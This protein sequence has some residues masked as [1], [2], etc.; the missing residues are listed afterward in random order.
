MAY[1][2]GSRAW[3]RCGKGGH[4]IDHRR[5]IEDDAFPQLLVDP[6]WY[7]PQ[8]PQEIPVDAEDPQAIYRPAVE[9]GMGELPI[10]PE[11]VARVVFSMP[12]TLAYD[13]E[14]APFTVT[15]ESPTYAASFFGAEVTFTVLRDVSDGVSTVDYTLLDG[16][17]VASLDYVGA[18]GT[19]TFNDGESSKDVTVTLIPAN[20]NAEVAATA[21][22]FAHWPLGETSGTTAADVVNGLDMVTDTGTVLRNQARNNLSGAASSYFNDTAGFGRVYPPEFLG[23]TDICIEGW[24]TLLDNTGNAATFMA[25]GGPS[26]DASSSTNWQFWIGTVPSG[27]DAVPWM[28]WEHGVGVNNTFTWTATTFPLNTPVYWKY[29][30][31]GGATKKVYFSANDGVEYELPWVNAPT[32]GT[33]ARLTIGNMMDDNAGC[34]ARLSNVA[35]Y[36]DDVNP[37]RHERWKIGATR[38]FSA[39]LS[40]PSI[41][42]TIIDD[43]TTITLNESGV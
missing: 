18:S 31:T 30:R 16:T 39:V 33:S 36:S 26:T 35:L 25:D 4:R 1:A 9:G 27:A 23:L 12:G 2:K 15:M 29:R 24:A 41:G 21:S 37:H 34:H 22:I 17:A 13:L 28:F 38:G 19:V 10:D 11:G 3:G 14:Y 20:Y 6:V 8:H 43:T 5:L 7:E 40:N 32:G 42:G